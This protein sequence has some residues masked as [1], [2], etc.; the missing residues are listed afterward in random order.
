MSDAIHLNSTSRVVRV[1]VPKPLRT[2]FDYE[3]PVMLPMPRPGARVRVPFGPGTTIGVAVECDTAARPDVV[4]KPVTEV[5][6]AT[7]VLEPSIL[8]LTRWAADYYHHPVGDALFSALPAAL[9]DGAGLETLYEAHWRL[10]AVDPAALARA[11]RQRALADHLA[12]HSGC[13][14][15]VDLHAAG[16]D[17]RTLHALEAR[18]A[19][20]RYLDLPVAPLERRSSDVV[21]NADQAAAVG[22][23]RAALGRFEAVLL[24]GITGSGKTEVYLSAIDTVLDAGRQALVLVPEIAL[25]PQTI[26]RFERRFGAAAAYHS[27]LP[28]R[29][30]GQVWEACRSG[31]ARV[32]VGT[33]SA[34]F[35][36]FA[37]L[38]IIV[39]DEEHDGS[40][41]QQDGFRY[42]A[43][44]L[45]VIRARNA[46]IPVVFG[47]ATP[48]LETLHNARVGRYRHLRLHARAG[49]ASPPRLRVVDLR[50]QSLTEG[51]SAELLHA[52]DAH[53]REGNQALLFINRRGYAPS[54][55]CTQCGWT[56][57]CDRCTVRFTLHLHPPE[58]R[59]HH[60]G[61][62]R[63]VPKTCP[64]CGAEGLRPVGYG[65]QRTEQALL[66]RYP[67]VPVI[68]VDRD[69]TR[70]TARLEAHLDAI[71]RGEPALLVG[72]QM[73]AKGHHF[74]RVTLVA[75]LNADAGFASADFRAPEHSAQLITQVA[76][77]A[78]RAERAGEVLIQTFDPDNA[79]LRS[80]VEE[81]YDGF[82]D[83]ELGNR[84]AAGLPPF[85]AMALLRAE[86]ADIGRAIAALAELIAPVRGVPRL[87]VWGPVPAPMARRADRYRAQ[88]A[89]VADERPYLARLLDRVVD[90]T[91]PRALRGVRWSIDV[92]PYDMV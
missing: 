43:R 77:R 41:K 85:R 38:G 58:L 91:D 53:L 75:V 49:A 3:V 2:L 42:S 59:C 20:A 83:R 47:T 89:L 16:F 74:P 79:L 18:G 45:A 60:C 33:R 72:T 51:M 46:D 81:G 84:A 15:E 57:S 65:T 1:A 48:A 50:G 8:T 52:V 32:L 73:L 67:D 86:A 88:C 82:A 31:R 62:Q 80:L 7:P 36:P 13:A 21:L 71:E 22:A 24:H 70:S 40:F 17:T 6:D 68:R 44:D 29:A 5:L 9:R 54:F 19:I 76:G 10:T 55:L 78:G 35:V 63:P 61:V 4:L 56:A 34:I 25:T 92:D 69:S 64:S 66:A 28:E 87:D 11:P 90:A 27:G 14:S 12:A 23:L 30:R 26:R 37:D 39:V